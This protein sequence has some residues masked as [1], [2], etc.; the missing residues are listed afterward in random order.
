MGLPELAL[1][2]SSLQRAFASCALSGTHGGCQDCN[3]GLAVGLFVLIASHQ[4]PDP[5]RTCVSG[6][7]TK[8]QMP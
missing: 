5:T 1:T 6:L 7:Q 3:L 4:E 2:Q 8:A